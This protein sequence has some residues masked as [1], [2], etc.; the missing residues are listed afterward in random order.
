[1]DSTVH[2]NAPTSS[3]PVERKLLPF[4]YTDVDPTIHPDAPIPPLPIEL[5]PVTYKEVV[6]NQPQEQQLSTIGPSNPLMNNLQ[7]DREEYSKL[8]HD[9]HAKSMQSLHSEGYGKLQHPHTDFT[10]QHQSTVGGYSTL[11]LNSKYQTQNER[12][13]TLPGQISSPETREDNCYCHFIT[14]YNYLS[15]S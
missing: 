2:S 12:F 15:Y 9:V 4:N 3:S 14:S 6:H 11:P 1:M 10:P 5:N 8:N 7:A 13:T